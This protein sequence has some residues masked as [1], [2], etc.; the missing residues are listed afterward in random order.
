MCREIFLYF[1]IIIL[2][3][4]HTRFTILFTYKEYRKVQNMQIKRQPGK[5]EK[6]AIL[7]LIIIL[8]AW[9][10]RA[11]LSANPSIIDHIVSSQVDSQMREITSS[12]PGGTSSVLFDSDPVTSGDYKEQMTKVIDSADSVLQNK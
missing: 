7:I 8:T 2:E 5:F 3:F 12:L 11:Y 10:T 1:S 9:A 4:P 6:K